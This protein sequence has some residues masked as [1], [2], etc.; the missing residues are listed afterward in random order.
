MLQ[1]EYGPRLVCP[2]DFYLE[3]TPNG[4]YPLGS[5]MLRD[6]QNLPVHNV[7]IGHFTAAMAD[8][9]PLRYLTATF[10]REPIQRSLSML[11]RFQSHVE[12]PCAYSARGSAVHDRQDRRFPDADSRCGW[13]V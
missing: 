4:W 10:L 1:D 6:S 9:L 2:G 11:G 5:E 7:L 3:H 12:G 13:G 8:W